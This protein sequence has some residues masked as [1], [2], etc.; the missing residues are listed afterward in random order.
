MCMLFNN[1]L[2]FHFAHIVYHPGYNESGRKN[3]RS[4]CCPA[5]SLPLISVNT[6]HRRQCSSG[7]KRSPK[8]TCY[9]ALCHLDSHNH[10]PSPK[11]LSS[12]SLQ[13]SIFISFEISSFTSLSS[14]ING[15][16]SQ[17]ITFCSPVLLWSSISPNPSSMRTRMSSS[18][19]PP[20]YSKR[21]GAHP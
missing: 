14:N 6:S 17:P 5:A 21:P 7:A 9:P 13:A 3:S 20:P 15:S 16:M 19:R 18:P 11:P 4:R 10:G 8:A 2:T 1:P 12:S